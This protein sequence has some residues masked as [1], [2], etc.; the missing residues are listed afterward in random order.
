[1]ISRQIF[2][3]L[4]GLDTLPRYSISIFRKPVPSG[5]D[6]ISK[7]IQDHRRLEDY[8]TNYMAAKNED[9]SYKWFNLFIWEVSRHAVAEE[10]VLYGLLEEQGEKGKELSRRSREDHR[11]MKQILEDLRHE[12][13]HQKFDKKFKE[14]FM[15]LAEHLNYEERED[16][17]FLKERLTEDQ[18]IKA[19]KSFT[20]KEKI[21]P[22]R[23][24]PNVPNRSVSLENALGVLLAPVDKLKDMFTAFPDKDTTRKKTPMN[25]KE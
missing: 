8:F 14:T 13:D 12:K 2:K 11:K 1:M 9:D 10:I 16:L 3:V 25:I 4:R 5:E 18:L 15:D 19:G 17:P 23:P 21:A 22:T 6:I 24:H 20:M 7:V